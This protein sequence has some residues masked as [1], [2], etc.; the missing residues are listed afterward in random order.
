[1]PQIKLKFHCWLSKGVDADGTAYDERPVSA[2]EGETLMALIRRL[3]IDN[4]F[5]QSEIFDNKNSII[6]EG[7][8][9][10]LNGRLVNP[11]ESAE[12]ILK[13]GDVIVFLPAMFGG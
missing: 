4:D 9:V 8:I 3:S 5:F 13:E 12:T 1:M 11:Y 7:V 6:K 10:L 2:A